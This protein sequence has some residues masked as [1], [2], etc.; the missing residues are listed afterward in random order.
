MLFVLKSTFALLLMNSIATVQFNCEHST[1]NNCLVLKGSK[2][3]VIITKL[4]KPKKFNFNAIF[5]G[6]YSFYYSTT[7]GWCVGCVC[8]GNLC[9]DSKFT[10]GSRAIIL[11]PLIFGNP[12]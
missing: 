4:G 10:F 2:V 6:V 11:E 9:V 12:D 3:D 1:P 8:I 5:F 7:D